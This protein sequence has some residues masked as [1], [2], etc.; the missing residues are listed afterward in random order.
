M[1]EI[2][3]KQN[4]MKK[5]NVYYRVSVESDST[6]ENQFIECI[7]TAMAQLESKI[8]SNKIKRGLAFKKTKQNKAK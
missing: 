2:L 4:K 7:T 3:F 1:K 6:P 8:I 5:V